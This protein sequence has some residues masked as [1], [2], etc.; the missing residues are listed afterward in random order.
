VFELT[1]V[2]GGGWAETVLHP[3]SGANSDRGGAAPSTSLVFDKV[4]NLYGTTSTG[5]AYDAGV[6]FEVTP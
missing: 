6:V 1:P 5:G 2:A 4:G 3:F